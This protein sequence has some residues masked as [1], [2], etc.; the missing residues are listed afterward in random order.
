MLIAVRL[1]CQQVRASGR[2]I[3]PLV[4][5]SSFE[6]KQ[7]SNDVVLVYHLVGWSMLGKIPWGSE[8]P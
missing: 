5:T 3:L 6:R 1:P 2:K 8:E 4:Q 7:C